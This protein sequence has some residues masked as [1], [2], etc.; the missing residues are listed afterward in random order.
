L[1]YYDPQITQP[2]AAQPGWPGYIYPALHGAYGFVYPSESDTRPATGCWLEVNTSN[3]MAVRRYKLHAER[4]TDDFMNKLQVN[5][6]QSERATSA[7]VFCNNVK[8]TESSLLPARNPA[9]LTFTVN[10]MPLGRD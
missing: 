8:L 5:I 7:A 10:G 2:T 9:D 3:P 1:G 6:P 4:L